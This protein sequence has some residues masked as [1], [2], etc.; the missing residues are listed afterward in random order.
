MANSVQWNPNPTDAVHH[1]E[2]EG[3]EEGSEEKLFAFFVLF[4][5]SFENWG[6]DGKM[7]V[8]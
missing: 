1:E 3:H 8:L 7:R 6:G 4:V 5:S 2:H